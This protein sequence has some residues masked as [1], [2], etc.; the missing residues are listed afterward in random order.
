MKYGAFCAA[1]KKTPLKQVYLLSGVESF[2]IEKAKERILKAI[3]FDGEI[4]VFE[5]SNNLS[6]ITAA[7]NT[8]PLFSPK[9]V[10]L[11]KDANIFKEKKTDNNAKEKELANFIKD[12]ETMP[13]DSYIIFIL[14]DAPDK[15]RKI[16]KSAEKIGL[17]LETEEVRPWTIGEWL[18]DKLQSI[19]KS[20]DRDAN[21]FFMNLVGIMKEIRL[22]YL[23]MEFDKLALY[24]K[25]KRITRKM[26]EEV[27]SSIPEVSSFALVDAVGEKNV[28]KSIRILQREVETGAF[29]PLIVGLLARYVRQLLQIKM[30][31]KEFVRGRALAAPLG[32]NPVIAERLEKTAAVFDEK[33]LETALIL[34]SDADYLIKTGQ[35]GSELL[36]EIILVLCEKRKV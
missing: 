17:V 3:D 1:L 6:D 26:L 2:Y 21:I 31:V 32:L 18:T 29:I 34:L 30:L 9:T 19:D 10:V 36:E 25:E 35:G 14:N 20:F 27:F 7:I 13:Q 12:L 4:S 16:F 24:T 15:R 5:N 22:S 23:D 28:A 33:T 8:A 11:V